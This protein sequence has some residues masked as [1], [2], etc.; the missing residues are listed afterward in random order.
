[1]IL[2]IT[3]EKDWAEA[4]KTGQYSHETL[5]TEGFIHCSKPEQILWVANRFYSG[6][7]DLIL[8]F[9]QVEKVTHEIKWE[10]SE[11]GAELFPH[12]YGT[13]NVNAVLETKA[14]RANEEGKFTTLP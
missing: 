9:I 5:K 3:T 4:Q 2:H 10:N 13:L 8:L 12:I 1:M 14:F 11:G 6:R 7:Q